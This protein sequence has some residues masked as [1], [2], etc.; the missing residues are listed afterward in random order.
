MERRKY[1]LVAWDVIKRPLNQSGLDV[2]Y[3]QNEPISLGLVDLTIYERKRHT[4]AKG[5]R[6]KVWYDG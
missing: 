6:G 2:K 5:Y 4:L 1:H 3:G